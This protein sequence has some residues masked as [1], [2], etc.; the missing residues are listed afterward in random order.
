MVSLGSFSVPP[1]RTQTGSYWTPSHLGHL[2]GAGVNLLAWVTSAVRHRA[3]RATQAT[4]TASFM[5]AERRGLA[6][7]AVAVTG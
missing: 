6:A 2:L 7:A 1:V 4:D 3:T 5:L